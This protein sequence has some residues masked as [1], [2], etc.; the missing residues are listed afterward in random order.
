LK[1]N[2]D[3]GISNLPRDETPGSHQPEESPIRL[4]LIGSS[5][6]WAPV[7]PGASG[8]PA[9]EV[10]RTANAQEASA[11]ARAGAFDLVLWDSSEPGLEAYQ[12]AVAVSTAPVLRMAPGDR[13][14]GAA[15]TAQDQRWRLH[16]Q[17]TP[18]AVIEWNPEGR[19]QSWNPAAERMFGYSAEE[20]FGQPIIELIV[21]PKAEVREQVHRIAEGLTQDQQRSRAEHENK[22]K[23]GSTLLCRWF[24]TPLT[25]EAGHPLGVA[26]MALDV[27][28][29]QRATEALMESEHR[30]RTVADFTYDWEYWIAQDGS[31]PWMSPSCERITG[32]SVEAFQRDP[33]LLIRICHPEDRALLREHVHE[34]LAEGG[35]SPVEFRIRHRDGRQ[36]WISHICAQVSG[37]QG[38]PQGRRVSNRDITDRKTAEKDL[39][40]ASRQRLAM[41]EAASVA[42][43]V[44]WSREADGNMAWG[45]SAVMVLGLSPADLAR[46][47]DWPWELIIE[48]D[49]PQLRRALREAEAGLV[50]SAECRMRHQA[51]GVIWTRWTLA[52]EQGIFHGAVQDVS[53][54]HAVQE[55]LLQSQ[56]LESL[57]V[58]VG[59]VAHDFNNLLMAILGYGQIFEVD[60]GF[61]PSQRKGLEAIQ[62][63]ATR[64]RELAG[65]LLGFSRKAEPNR[66]PHSLDEV[67]SEACNLLSRA[68]PK[69]IHLEC[70]LHGSL[71]D[72]F[73]DPGRIHQVVMNLVI[74]ARDAI[75]D[76]GRI[77]LRTDVEVVD[78][79]RALEHQRPPGSYVVLHVEDTGCGIP[80]ADLKRILEPFYSTKGA[81][82][83]GLGL[84]VVNSIVMEHGGFMECRSTVGKGTRFSVYLPQTETHS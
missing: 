1:I 75:G 36:L 66:R 31:L 17:Q 79:G 51:G 68:L 42:R 40:E 81:Q 71:P 65:R 83:T 32:Y 72:A 23:D 2:D 48:E 53:D 50:A 76:E 47:G 15:L 84:S 55:Q 46:L 33:D 77:S 61:T 24:N 38:E 73:F 80:A 4:L 78:A 59:G 35:V 27:T 34:A 67:V 25:D 6:A 29:I 30:F 39:V 69:T 14:P 43:V 26:S 58:L 49:R 62:R 7:P 45:D 16:L 54:Q 70:N 11:L 9:I 18:L 74:N 28:E 3:V 60:P 41:L 37:P 52:L 20:A 44:P 19:V 56:K 63:A 57:G 21:P 8:I 10:V 22:R 64:G 82:G 5:S 12:Q 13:P